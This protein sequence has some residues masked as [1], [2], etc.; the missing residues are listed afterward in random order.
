MEV[1]VFVN[2]NDSISCGQSFCEAFGEGVAGEAA[3]NDKYILGIWNRVVGEAVEFCGDEREALEGE[4]ECD[5]DDA[6]D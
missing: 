4:R 6:Q 2:E 3:A 5:G 1:R